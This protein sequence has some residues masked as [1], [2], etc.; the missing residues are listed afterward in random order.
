MDR[1]EAFDVGEEERLRAEIAEAKDRYLRTLADFDNY[2]K[3]VERERDE[4]GRAGKRDVLIG[5][6]DL[7]D[8]FDRAVAAAPAG[9]PDPFRAGIL[10]IYR[11]LQRLLDQYGV[12]QLESI[13]QPFDPELHEAIGVVQAPGV[14]PGTVVEQARP[15]YTWDGA[16]LRPA[17]VLVAAEPGA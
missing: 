6:V 16:L 14:E 1:M 9:D 3:R 15:G 12:A 7:A 11:Q 10:A 5:L 17:K 2:R 13:G 8:S 4:I